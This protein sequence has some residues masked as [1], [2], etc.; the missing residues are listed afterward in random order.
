VK[1]Y[2]LFAHCFTCGKDLKPF[3]N[4]NRALTDRDIGV[5]RFDFSGLGRSEGDFSESNIY[6]NET[7]V[8]DAAAFLE[9]NF[10]A[11]GILIGHSMG[12]VTVL[13]SAR[14]VTSAKAVV[15]IASPA[16]PN[17]L[18]NNLRRARDEAKKSGEAQVSIG[19]RTY[20]LKKQFFDDLDATRIK[21]DIFDLK[22]ALLVLHS[23]DDTTVDIGNATQIFQAARHP[24]SFVSLY[25]A[26]HLLLDERHARY[27]GTVIAAWLDN[28]L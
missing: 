4:M 23:P 27:A 17:H 1:A 11:P 12:G 15:T 26:D 21:R 9:K 25:G 6:S 14:A 22:K 28:Y 13:R 10:A 3:A 2:A 20:T 8:L 16:D 18:G 7:D 5:L 24:K 19:G